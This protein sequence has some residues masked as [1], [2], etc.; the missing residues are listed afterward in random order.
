VDRADHADY[1]HALSYNVQLT[2]PSPAAGVTANMSLPAA[3]DAFIY[4]G[5]RSQ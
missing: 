2:M 3:T 5:A 4:T 1:S